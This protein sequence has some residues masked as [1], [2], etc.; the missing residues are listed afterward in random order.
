MSSDTGSVDEP[1]TAMGERVLVRPP[2]A[3]DEPAY[4]EAVT[5]SSRRLADFAMPDPHNLSLIHI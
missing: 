1:L 3:A 5:R 4:V 2:T